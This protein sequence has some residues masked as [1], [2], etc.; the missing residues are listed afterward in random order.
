MTNQFRVLTPTVVILATFACSSQVEAPKREIRNVL[1]ISSD[2]HAAY[3]MGAYGN[4]I[5][6]TPNLDRLAASGARFDSAYANCPFCTPSRQSIITGKLPHA[7]GV[8]L[9]R[10]ALSEDE[11]TI[12]EHLKGFGFKTAAVGK[13]HFNS[14]LTHG[15]DY[16]IDGKDHDAYLAEHPARKPP[17]EIPYKPVWRPFRVP[18]REW[19]NAGVLPG[20]AYPRPGDFENQGLYDDDFTSTFF[21]RRAID[22][23]EQNRDGRMCVWLSYY[24]PHSPYNFPIEFTKNNDPSQMPLPETSPEDARWVPAIFRDIADEDKRGIVASYYNSVEYLDKNVG[25]AL[26]ALEKLGLD[27]S[28]LV[29]YVAD[30]GYLLGHHG[31]FEK[32]MMWEE[33]VR[34]PLVIRDPRLQGG[35]V[36]SAMVEL[37]DLVPTILD[38]L[39]VAPIEGQQGKSLVPLLEGASDHHR[40]YVFSE[41]FHDNK[42]MVRTAEWKYIFTSGKKDLQLGY[43]TGKGP[44]GRDQRLYHMI[45]DPSEFK[46]VAGDPRHHDV[47]QDLRAKMLDVFMTTD[48]RAPDLPKGLSVEEKLEWFLEPPEEGKS[49]QSGG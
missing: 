20:T 45:D 30:H 17:P 21:T 32:H 2:D 27:D 39:D 26:G 19:L 8:T 46:D 3:V 36:I 34:V 29:I 42:A 5:I 16:R 23:L 18:A 25:L 24:E 6:Q 37:V 33:I 7:T 14:G 47:I 15:F 4:S 41:Y 35:K 40:D 1:F 49:V 11:V 48:P 13:M 31:R 10:T 38:I 28:T 9:V 22:F 43:E 44:S 12:A